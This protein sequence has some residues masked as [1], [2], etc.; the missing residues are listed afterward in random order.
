VLL[1]RRLLRVLLD[2]SPYEFQLKNPQIARAV[3]DSKLLPLESKS[4]PPKSRRQKL[5]AC[6]PFQPI[7]EPT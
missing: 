4:H 2:E 3:S 1:A 5:A 6:G 7:T